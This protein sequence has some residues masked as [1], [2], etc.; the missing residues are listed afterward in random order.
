[1]FSAQCS[2]NFDYAQSPW[3]ILRAE[4][5]WLSVYTERRRGGVEAIMT[6]VSTG[7]FIVKNFYIS[8]H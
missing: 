5:W 6:P 2:G 7:R 1:M 8:F 4:A 3:I